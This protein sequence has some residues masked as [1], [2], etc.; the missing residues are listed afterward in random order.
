MVGGRYSLWFLVGGAAL[1]VISHASRGA[2]RLSPWQRVAD[3]RAAKAEVLSARA[4][5]LRTPRED[6]GE[7]WLQLH[8][9]KAAIIIELAG[10]EALGD[11]ELLYLLADCL[12]NAEAAAQPRAQ[13]ALLAALEAEPDH[14]GAAGAWYELGH[15][16]EATQSFELADEAYARALTRQWDT[17]VRAEIFRARAQLNMRLK[18]LTGAIEWYRAALSETRDAETRAWA[19]WGLAVALDRSWDLPAALPLA[20]EAF[21]SGFG[22]TGKASVLDVEE[23][24]L[25]PLAEVHYYRGLA[26]LAEAHAR[27]GDD[28][29]V[30]FL[31][32][33]QLMW[34]RYLD[35]TDPAQPWVARAKEHLEAVREHL[36]AQAS[37]DEEDPDAVVRSAPIAEEPAR[38]G[39]H[40]EQTEQEEEADPDFDPDAEES[41]E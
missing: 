23:G 5:V 14:P 41:S 1:I 4:D 28:G 34:V 13:Q 25:W 37:D 27:R 9:H 22:P 2:A 17:E 21:R 18:N 7:R 8:N 11:P 32:A 16:A 10:G 31:L 30:S 26:L 24:V 39:A 15:V 33:S 19:L 38:P 3:P 12:A 20:L 29:E 35:E 6:L 40:G 36:A